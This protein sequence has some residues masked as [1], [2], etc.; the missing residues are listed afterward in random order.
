MALFRNAKESNDFS[1]PTSDP[2]PIQIKS[3]SRNAAGSAIVIVFA[4]L[5]VVFSIPA[6]NLSLFFAALCLAVLA[7]VLSASLQRAEDCKTLL[8]DIRDILNLQTARLDAIS[9]AVQ[10]GSSPETAQTLQKLCDI[11]E[12]S[13][14]ILSTLHK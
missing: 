6:G 11:A 8:Y 3:H 12:E 5:I 13:R 4:I 10:P 14:D 7:Y 9:R 2:Q 1:N